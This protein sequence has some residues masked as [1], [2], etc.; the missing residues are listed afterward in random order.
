MKNDNI[1]PGT[2]PNLIDTTTYQYSD[3]ILNIFNSINYMK[4][5]VHSI[6]PIHG[7]GTNIERTQIRFISSLVKVE[8]GDRGRW[9]VGTPFTLRCP[10]VSILYSVNV[11]LPTP[12]LVPFW[13]RILRV[14]KNE[15]VYG[16]EKNGS[17]P[18]VLGLSLLINATF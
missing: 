17:W 1:V 11:E 7:F 10:L 5:N 9:N 18:P 15:R 2:D 4:S 14:T 12:K 13:T 8:A 6:A 3:T 16:E